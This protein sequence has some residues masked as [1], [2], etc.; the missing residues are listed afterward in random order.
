MSS[1]RIQKF[2]NNGIFIS[3]FGQGGLNRPIDVAADQ[4]GRI[5]SPDFDNID[6]HTHSIVTAHNDVF[7]I[8][9]S[10]KLIRLTP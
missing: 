10:N 1:N 7:N 3:K 9:I 8:S 2:H 5:Y 6:I 4:M